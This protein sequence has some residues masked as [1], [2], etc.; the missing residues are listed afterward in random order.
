MRGRKLRLTLL[1]LYAR[2]LQAFGPRRW[3]PGDT[4]L[5]IAV[6]AI[7]TQ[8]TGWTNVEKAI[9]NLKGAGCLSVG[10]L[11]ELPAGRLAALIRPSGYFR[12]KAKKLKAFIRFLDARFSGSMARMR[13]A[14]PARLRHELLGIWGIGPETADSIL[15]YAIEKPVFVVDAYTRRILSRHF[16][17]RPTATYHEI[18]TYV[19][20]R[21]PR[22][23]ALYNDFHAQI[24]HLG[25]HFCNTTPRCAGCPLEPFPRRW[26]VKSR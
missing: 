17:V 6:G 15:C 13:R 2:L 8:N 21:I 23:T 18:Q 4:P 10:E 24:V 20:E 9:A 11:R 1:D 16:F 12:Q 7:L 3:W 5:E 26:V 14:D 25:K 22:D 19:I